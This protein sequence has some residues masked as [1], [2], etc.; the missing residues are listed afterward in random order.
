MMP[1]LMLPA[2]II[3]DDIKVPTG[4]QGREGRDFLSPIRQP[5]RR[6]KHIHERRARM[7]ACEGK[8]NADVF[9][10]PSRPGDAVVGLRPVHRAGWRT[11]PWGWQP[12]ATAE[13]AEIA[14]AT[15]EAMKIANERAHIAKGAAA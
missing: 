2:D 1:A 11:H 4:R 13:T 10:R 9:S 14:N 8:N 7:Y 5:K 3:G 15:P 6:N 12:L